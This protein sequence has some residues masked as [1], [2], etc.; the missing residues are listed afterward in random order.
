MGWSRSLLRLILIRYLQPKF[1]YHLIIQTMINVNNDQG[2]NHFFDSTDLSHTMTYSRHNLHVQ[3]PPFF[4]FTTTFFLLSETTVPLLGTEQL[5]FSFLP[6]TV[7]IKEGCSRGSSWCELLLVFRFGAALCFG[8]KKYFLRRQSDKIQP[9]SGYGIMIL[10]L[11]G[12][13]NNYEGTAQGDS[14]LQD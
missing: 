6:Y 5:L 2:R 7:S 10:R 11:C 13:D 9:F 12:S 1:F 14:N 4:F 3:L 8:S